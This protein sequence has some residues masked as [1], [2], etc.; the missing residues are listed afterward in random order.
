MAALNGT[1]AWGFFGAAGLG[2]SSFLGL[3]TL[4]KVALAV[5]FAI[6]GSLVEDL[7]RTAV[8]QNAVFVGK[9][10]EFGD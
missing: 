2:I 7:A 9:V 10:V 1:H 8:L 6:K 5:V 4:S 3:H